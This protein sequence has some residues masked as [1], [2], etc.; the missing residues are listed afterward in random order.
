MGM[1]IKV[2]VTSSTVKCFV[3]VLVKGVK[4]K[5]RLFEFKIVYY[6]L[7]EKYNFSIKIIF[8][9]AISKF[10]GDCFLYVSGCGAIWQ[11]ALS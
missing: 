7:L 2:P 8:K 11:D 9:E 5:E 3:I 1:P 4:E 6:E 10:Q